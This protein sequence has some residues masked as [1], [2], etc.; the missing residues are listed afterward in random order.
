MTA[1]KQRIF[2]T[3]ANGYIGSVITELATA[4]GY[5]VHGLSRSEASDAKLQSLGAV[6]V[7]GD[8]TSLDVLRKESAE[9]DI[10]IH[11]A[12]A[13][14][15]GEGTYDAVLPVDNAA[16][17]AIADSLA[18]TG[19]P[20]VVTSGTLTTGADP[21][22]AETTEASPPDPSPINSR[23]KAEA[24]ALALA[25][26]GI[27]VT[28]VRLAPY[29]YG[30]AGSGVKLFMGMSAKAGSVTRVAGG[31]NRTTTVHVDDAARLYLLAAQQ[32]K[33][34]DVFNASSATDVTARQLF[35]AMA[36]ALGLPLRDISFAQA[37]TQ[38]GEVFA[39]FLSAENRA[40]GEKARGVLG[41]EPKGMG[42]LDEI[43]R[44]SYPALA[45]ELRKGAA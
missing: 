3:G 45:A 4:D 30:R 1:P 23:G 38:L 36:A 20:L 37:Q 34:G 26:R 6:P 41:W 29:V 10:V 35:E 40:S 5:A 44:G 18:G 32:G 15:I 16:V 12:T 27:R 14:T 9:A 8:L 2:M 19:K 11:L 22:G 13:Y 17:D 28:S 39:R 42:I 43:S 33:P 7:R 24:H 31:T 21:T 25:A